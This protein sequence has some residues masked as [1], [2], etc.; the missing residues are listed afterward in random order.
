MIAG[1]RDVL[2]VCAVISLLFGGL[3]AVLRPY[4][5]PFAEL[6]G[7]IMGLQQELADT[8]I[9]LAE[10]RANL[11]DL[12]EPRIVEFQGIG[13][14]TSEKAVKAGGAISVLYSLR[15]N[16]SCDTEVQRIFYDV[17]RNVFVQAGT[18]WAIKAPVTTS[19]IPFTVTD[20][21]IPKNLRPGRYV[22]YPELTPVDCRPYGAIRVPM[23]SVFEV[24]E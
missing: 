17:D 9:E 16:A 4:W 10:L 6:P 7:Q 21:E 1:L 15:R 14:V 24:T 23:S 5:E 2:V 13:V 11:T 20:I 19:F 22:Y 3:S 12:T 18:F 8:N